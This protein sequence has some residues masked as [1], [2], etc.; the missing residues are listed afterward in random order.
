MNRLI[1][2]LQLLGAAVLFLF[3][4]LSLINILFIVT[5]EETISVVNAMIGLGVLV[6]CLTAIGTVLYKKGLH[7]WRNQEAAG[8]S[9]RIT[10]DA[11]DDSRQGH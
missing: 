6:I 11:S 8:T 9:G 1:A 4:L 10:S 5:R 7:N 3:A 2:I